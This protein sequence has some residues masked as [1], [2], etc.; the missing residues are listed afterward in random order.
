MQHE[1]AINNASINAIVTEIQNGEES[2]FNDH[3]FEEVAELA[4]DAAELL[5][6][7]KMYREA[8]DEL[9]D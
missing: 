2:K 3:E 9:R 7:T 1:F 8:V 6:L 4:Q 5:P